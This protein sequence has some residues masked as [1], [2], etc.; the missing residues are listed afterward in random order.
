MKTY[1]VHVT[2]A[3]YQDCIY[4]VQ[5]ESEAEALEKAEAGATVKEEEDGSHELHRRE[6][7]IHTVELEEMNRWQHKLAPGDEVT[8]NDPDEGFISMA[9]VIQTIEWPR[10]DLARILFTHGQE[11]EAL[12]DELS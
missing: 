1:T 4:T 7:H 6:V 11:L 8:W 10:P 12:A 2:E 9:G 5:A 3:R